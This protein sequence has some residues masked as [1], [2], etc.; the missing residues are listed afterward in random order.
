MEVIETLHGHSR[1]NVYGGAADD[2]GAQ[3]DQ[4]AGRGYGA[5]VS[6]Y[7][8]IS[9]GTIFTLQYASYMVFACSFPIW[10]MC[11]SNFPFTL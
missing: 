4:Y 2:V 9:Y 8:T 6:R 5:G 10:G 7:G 1:Q 11:C 3:G